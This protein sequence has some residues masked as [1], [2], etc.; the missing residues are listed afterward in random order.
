MATIRE[1]AKRAGVS[2]ATVS[3]VMNQSEGISTA[4]RK[5]V[6]EAIMALKYSPFHNDANLVE[7]TIMAVVPNTISD[8]QSSIINSLQEEAANLNMELIIGVCHNNKEMLEK[9]ICRLRKR[10]VQALIFLG[11][12]MSAEQ[13]NSLARDYPICLCGDYIEGTHFLSVVSDVYQSTYEAITH[14][15]Q[16]GFTKIGMISTITRVWSSI[17]KEAAYKKALAD[18]GIAFKPEYILFNHFTKPCEDAFRYFEALPEPP[19]AIFAVSDYLASTL[20]MPIHNQGYELGV[21]YALLGFDNTVYS[22]LSHVPISTI[23][24][25]MQ[26]IGQIA[27]QRIYAQLQNPRNTTR[28]VIVVPSQVILRDSTGDFSGTQTLI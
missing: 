15:I 14:L 9:C 27:V 5:L 11:S 2:T 8:F 6:N 24:Q 4:N 19:N 21:D 13:L 10:A 26:E 20:V 17:Q 25:N 22:T 3:R 18:H 23:A 12:D 7:Q 28:K 1:V 16:K